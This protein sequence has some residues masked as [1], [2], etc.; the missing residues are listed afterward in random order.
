ML[1]TLHAWAQ[2]HALTIAFVLAGINAITKLIPDATMQRV[3]REYPRLANALR[4]LRS[5]G[6]DTVK[7]ARA[8]VDTARGRVKEDALRINAALTEKTPG[9]APTESSER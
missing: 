6:P 8:A 2:A 9:E 5:F 1:E 7:A 3:E 4:F